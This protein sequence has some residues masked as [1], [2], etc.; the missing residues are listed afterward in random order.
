MHLISH[1]KYWVD[2]GVTDELLPELP[3][4]FG[5]Q[6]QRSSAGTFVNIQRVTP[7]SPRNESSCWN[8]Y[9]H[10]AVLRMC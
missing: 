6:I 9:D 4:L 1:L 7:P 10:L 8:G 2:G 3:P 5:R